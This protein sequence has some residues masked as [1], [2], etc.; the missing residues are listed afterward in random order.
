M[1]VFSI[2]IFRWISSSETELPI[3]ICSCFELSNF[4]YFQR[5]SVKEVSL[6][7]SREVV[8]RT[9]QSEKQTIQHQDYLCHAFVTNDGLGC[10]V[11][12][13]KEYPSR[14]AFN[15]INKAAEETLRIFTVKDLE[16]A[17]K[18]GALQTQKL[19][20]NLQNLLIKYQNPT[21]ADSVLKIQRDLDETKEVIVKSIDQLLVRGEKLEVL[22][23]KSQD[24]SFQ[25]KA[26]L[27][28]SQKMNSCCTIL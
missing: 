1:K 5:N 16:G 27:T 15:L 11:I 7:V 9:K 21:E 22:A 17:T 19:E 25:S 13:D 20:A 3:L 6:F 14:V 10:A 18:E 8:G 23:E 28:Q 2:V 26:F 12:A 4:G 24:L